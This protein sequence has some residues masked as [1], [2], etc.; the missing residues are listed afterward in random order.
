MKKTEWLFVSIFVLF[1]AFTA[2]CDT[3]SGGSITDITITG[4]GISNNSVIKYMSS[5][6]S[7]SL[8]ASVTSTGNI[9]R[10]VIWD[11][12]DKTV[13]TVSNNGTVTLL[14]GGE[15]D[16]EA[17]SV[18]DVSKKA[19]LKLTVVDD[20]NG[21]GY[22][23]G[24]D[25][26][27]FNNAVYI[28][29]QTLEEGAIL[30]LSRNG[31]VST[32]EYNGLAAKSNWQNYIKISVPAGNYSGSTKFGLNLLCSPSAVIY[33]KLV[34]SRGRMIWEGDL[35]GNNLWTT[36]VIPLTFIE[37]AGL[38]DL[39]EMYIYVPKPGTSVYG[40]EARVGGIWL[41]GLDTPAIIPNFTFNEDNILG[42]IDLSAPTN[43]GITQSGIVPGTDNKLVLTFEGTGFSVGNSGY[44]DWK[45]VSYN[46]PGTVDYTNACWLVFDITNIS[47]RGLIKFKILNET[48]REIY[49][50]TE[51][52]YAAYYP[53][54]E[55]AKFFTGN[56]SS[57]VYVQ[58][59][60]SYLD[61]ASSAGFKLNGIY[62]ME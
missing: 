17:V 8:T 1:L 31:N 59:A 7:F 19:A 61:G 62:I 12:S 48:L 20:R 53:D 6:T 29:S 43:S 22:P 27:P 40:G 3:D 42:L 47:G 60:P 41:E 25:V 28:A 49:P 51:R 30:F 21:P 18:A 50:L 46:L 2:A 32:I 9:S 58:I 23:D 14:S 39:R 33:F 13:A 55:L 15:T 45:A 34:N 4:V 10:A 38:G 56:P 16:I 11:S 57:S 24:D 36:H 54:R 35:A 37:R 5:E 26:M 52:Y 44:N